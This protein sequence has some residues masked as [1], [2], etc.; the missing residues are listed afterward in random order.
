MNVEFINGKGISPS[1]CLL[2]IV[3]IQNQPETREHTHALVLNVLKQL[4]NTTENTDFCLPGASCPVEICA[5]VTK[6]SCWLTK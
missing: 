5:R 1:H 3:A 2:S 4:A 6:L